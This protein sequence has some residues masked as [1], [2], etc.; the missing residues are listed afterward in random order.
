MMLGMNLMILYS[1]NDDRPDFFL[2]FILFLNLF[3][4][5]CMARNLSLNIC[6]GGHIAKT[7]SKQLSGRYHRAR[8]YQNRTKWRTAMYNDLEFCNFR[9]FM[10]YVL[11]IAYCCEY[12]VQQLFD[13]KTNS[14]FVF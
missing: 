5:N 6:S 1:S 7:L 8:R 11:N 13:Q 10:H 2:L 3:F 4:F 14:P 9:A 12:R